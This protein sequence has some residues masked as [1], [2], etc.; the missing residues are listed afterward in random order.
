MRSCAASSLQATLPPRSSAVPAASPAL[1]L[2]SGLVRRRMPRRAR[3]ACRRS[4]TC[5]PRP[6][7]RWPPCG[8]TL[9]AGAT[10]PCLCGWR[11]MSP[12]PP[13]KPAP[14]PPATTS[15]AWA[16][17]SPPAPATAGP[18]LRAASSE[19]QWAHAPHTAQLALYRC[20]HLGLQ[21]SLRRRRR[22]PRDL[23]LLN[24]PVR[25]IRR[26]HHLPRLCHRRCR[27][28]CRLHCRLR[29]RLHCRHRLRRL[30]RLCQALVRS[31]THCHYLRPHRRR[32]YRHRRQPRL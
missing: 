15:S 1:A 32:Q 25:R 27:L 30:R 28:H 7:R 24:R 5:A 6:R 21:S 16:P 3:L 4:A 17:Q 9:A 20:L 18:A 13:A 23:R 29:C 12:S 14:S 26:I 31:L 2:A 10:A 22:R 19:A 11:E 8:N